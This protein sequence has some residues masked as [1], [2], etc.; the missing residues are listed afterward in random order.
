MII[1]FIS[2]NKVK[3]YT[4]VF[5]SIFI[6]IFYNSFNL[7]NKNFILK[8][9]EWLGEVNFEEV[10]CDG[11]V[12]N[13]S[14]N[15]TEVRSMIKNIY[16]G[17]LKDEKIVF[18]TFDDGPSINTEKILN[19]LDEKEVKATFFVVGG[20]LNTEENKNRL[21]EIYRNGHGIGNHSYSHEFSKLY[22][23]NRVQVDCF[24]DELKMT[25][26]I[27][28]GLLG[29]GHKEGMLIRMPGGYGSRKYYNDPNLPELNMRFSE[30][31]IENIDW[32]SLNGDA[33]GKNYSKE[34]M[35]NYVKNTAKGKKHV[36]VLMHDKEGKDK[37]VDV[38]PNIIDYFKEKGYVFKKIV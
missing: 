19:I 2:K 34:Q 4:L 9:D 5:L 28:E 13:D 18:L 33:E 14:V 12:D 8:R 16:D 10:A 36:V 26:E 3:I 38:L 7:F 27:I 17:P 32:N 22:K 25:Q 31:N 20:R 1:E 37:T 21:I 35:I 23:N 6:A 11:E 24:I 15:A 30:E 29:T